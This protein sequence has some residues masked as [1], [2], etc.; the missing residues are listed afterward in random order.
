MVSS[1]DDLDGSGATRNGSR[2]T[3]LEENQYYYGPGAASTSTTSTTTAAHERSNAFNG[4]HVTV[5]GLDVNNNNN[6]VC[7]FYFV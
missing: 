7:V 3:D 4:L 1:L 6:T 2:I 5:A